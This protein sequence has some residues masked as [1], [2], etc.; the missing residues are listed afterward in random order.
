MNDSGDINLQVV[1][2]P[3]LGS[4]P[5][6]LH[7]VG[8]GEAVTGSVGIEPDIVI[9]TINPFDLETHPITGEKITPAWLQDSAPRGLAHQFSGANWD[10]IRT[11][12]AGEEDA[13]RQ[14]AQVVVTAACIACVPVAMEAS[15]RIGGIMAGL[16]AF[17]QRRERR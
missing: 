1:F 5:K 4:T 9:V 16:I 7:P 8:E 17:A 13:E 11:N 10:G 2:D 14:A 15:N 3:P 12:L 6:K